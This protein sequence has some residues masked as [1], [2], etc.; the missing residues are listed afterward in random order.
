[1][2]EKGKSNARVLLA[3]SD[4]E[5][6]VGFF[7][8][9]DLFAQLMAAGFGD[10]NAGVKSSAKRYAQTVKQMRDAQKRGEKSIQDTT[11]KQV[12]AMTNIFLQTIEKL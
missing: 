9:D 8:P 7:N 1:M 11:E 4:V 12:D 6:N 3:L 2:T 10:I 5:G